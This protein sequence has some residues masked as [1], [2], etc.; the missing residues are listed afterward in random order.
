MTGYRFLAA[1]V[2]VSVFMGGCAG[3]GINID[4]GN[5]V[6]KPKSE[7]ELNYGFFITRDERKIFDEIVMLEEFGKFEKHFW[8]IRD[9]DPNTPENEF[10]E[11]IDGRLQDIKNEIFGTDFDI[12]GTRFDI[13]GG[14][15][16]DLARV[17]LLWGAPDPGNKERLP[18]GTYHTELMVW[19]YF[20]AT[21]RPL[22]RF[23]FYQSFEGR[24]RLFRDHLPLLSWDY[25]FDP[26]SSPLRVISNRPAITSS[27][28]LANVWYELERDDPQW[29]FRSA[30][31]EFSPYT[32]WVMEGGNNKNRFGALD[33]PEP[34]SLTAEKFKPTILG[35]PNIPEGTELFESGYHSF[36]PAYLRTSASPDNPTFL[37]LT[38]LRKNLDWV[39]QENEAK[40]Y[41]T[42]LNIRI[43]FQNKKTRKL[44]EFVSYFRF[45]LSQAEFD[46]RDDKGE[47]FGVS[48]ISPLT[49]QYF[50]GE[51]LGPT[52]GEMMK[53]L[54]PGEY[55]VNIY[56][57]H[58]ITKKYNPWREEIVISH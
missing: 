54:E 41:A 44:T 2:S 55:V 45:E 29:I 24:M 50:D 36:L 32:D 18:E 16:G 40:P 56:L 8:E 58:T 1:V 33:P 4:P 26:L 35:Q 7:F 52:L 9:T 31:F 6:Y 57:Q 12:P 51:K 23:L 49:L 25:L 42:N 47:L 53:Q 5:P 15:K 11:L 21:G 13:N 34:A 30:L 48:V 27:E 28:E 19:Y 20:D 3:K 46:K 43:S 22:F 17:Y 14:L 10:K 39:K 38:I 37:M